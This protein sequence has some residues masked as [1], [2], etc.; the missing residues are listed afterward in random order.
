VFITLSPLTSPSSAEGLP[1]SI[2]TRP[3]SHRMCLPPSHLPHLP[4]LHLL[5]L[6]SHEGLS[7][8]TSARPQLHRVGLRQLV[9]LWD[10]PLPS[11]LMSS[12]F[13][14]LSSLTHVL[15]GTFLA[16]CFETPQKARPPLLPSYLKESK[17]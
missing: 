7:V 4:Y 9:C 15:V 11:F 14:G 10:C 3:P 5:L 17:Y 8:S 13:Q 1:V 16:L 2:P 6:I 12:Q